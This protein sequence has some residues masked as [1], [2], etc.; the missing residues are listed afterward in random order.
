[1]AGKIGDLT[2]DSQLAF[3]QFVLEVAS[4]TI[5]DRVDNIVSENHTIPL[6]DGFFEK[7]ADG[8]NELANKI[9][10]DEDTYKTLQKIVELSY[11]TTAAGYHQF[12]RGMIEL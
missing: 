7:I 8:L 2:Y 1:M 5:S 12:L 11:V 4:S 10:N 6:V 9:E 3:M